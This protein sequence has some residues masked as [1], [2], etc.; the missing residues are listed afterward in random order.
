MSIHNS[1]P[2][3][4][5]SQE[6]RPAGQIAPPAPPKALL[7]ATVCIVLVAVS[8]LL[9]A[10][11]ALT[12]GKESLRAYAQGLLDSELNSGL[13]SSGTL[14]DIVVD[15]AFGA[16]QTRAYVWIFFAVAFLALLLP[17][18]KG[19]TWARVLLTLLGL[20]A[21]FMGLRDTADMVSPLL[22]MLGIVILLGTLV[23][24]FTWWLPSVN[25]YAKARK[26]MRTGR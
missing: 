17:I 13:D 10:V 2:G 4:D 23:A 16:L 20:G 3:N 26:R 25:R 24:A 6:T 5:F 8:A 12:T 7:V 14:L 18:R 22:G 9:S 11:V 19:S 1:F 15:E 21:M